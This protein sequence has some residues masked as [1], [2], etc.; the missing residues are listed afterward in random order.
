MSDDPRLE[1]PESRYEGFFL[2]SLDRVLAV[3]AFAV[4]AAIVSYLLGRFLHWQ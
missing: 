3:G 4:H 2:K 1:S